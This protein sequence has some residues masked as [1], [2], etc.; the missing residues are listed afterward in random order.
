MDKT[1]EIIVKYGLKVEQHHQYG[2]YGK[3]ELLDS[4]LRDNH[5]ERED[6]FNK[7]IIEFAQKYKKSTI[8]G[9]Y[10]D[11]SPKRSQRKFASKFY[12]TTFPNGNIYADSQCCKGF[13][14]G[15]YN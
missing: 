13:F 11:Q 3:A 6:Y 2:V 4:C 12:P 1:A 7:K 5:E 8:L 15:Q 10:L 9:N 14:Y